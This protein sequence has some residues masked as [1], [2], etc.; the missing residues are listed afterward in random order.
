MN[1]RDIIRTL[2]WIIFDLVDEYRQA[3]KAV[4]DPSKTWPPSPSAIEY[5]EGLTLFEHMN[6]RLADMQRLL[7]QV[8]TLEG[9]DE[10]FRTLHRKRLTSVRKLTPSERLRRDRQMRNSS[11]SATE[12]EDF[13]AETLESEEHKATPQ[14]VWNVPPLDEKGSSTKA[15]YLRR[16]LSNYRAKPGRTNH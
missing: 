9:M 6:T 1:E 16:R 14:V 3:H 7:E 2:T 4:F 12:S 11:L 13:E 10:R 5:S 8:N 15:Q